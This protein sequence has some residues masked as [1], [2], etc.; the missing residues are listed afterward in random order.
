[1]IDLLIKEKKI[2]HFIKLH[3]KQLSLEGQLEDFPF[4]L[5]HLTDTHCVFV[6]IIWYLITI[7]YLYKQ[8]YINKYTHF[9]MTYKGNKL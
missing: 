2:L 1:M 9:C 5:F 6:L 7:D 4:I 8:K 3:K